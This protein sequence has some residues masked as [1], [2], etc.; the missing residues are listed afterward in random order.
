MKHKYEQAPPIHPSPM[1]SHVLRH[2][3]EKPHQILATYIEALRLCVAPV[4]HFDE[5]CFK[6]LKKKKS[7]FSF[8]VKVVTGYLTRQHQPFNTYKHTSEATTCCLMAPYEFDQKAYLTI[9]QSISLNKK[10]SHISSD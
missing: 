5:N 6:V 1:A 3:L 4:K 2:I 8:L 10:N 7:D 9:S